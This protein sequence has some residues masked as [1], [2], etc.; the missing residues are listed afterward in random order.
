MAARRMPKPWF[1]AETERNRLLPLL[2]PSCLGVGVRPLPVPVAVG[3]AATRIEAYYCERCA[4]R[5]ERA[6]TLRAARWAA[7][8]LVGIGVAT[9]A[10]LSLGGS[11]LAL[12]I[13]LT[14]VASLLPLGI[15]WVRSVKA[16]AA[17]YRDSSAPNA[18][19]WLAREREYLRAL[20]ASAV[21]VPPPG[22]RGQLQRELVPVLVA[23]AWLA[24]LHWIGRAELRVIHAGDGDAIVLVDRRRHESFGPTR[25][26]HPHAA[27]AVSTLAGRRSLTLVSDEGETVAHVTATLMPGR[28]YLFGALPEG[29]CLF[30]ERREY[31]QRGQAHE[32]IALTR[33][34]PL[35]ELPV[36]VDVW[37]SPLREGPNLP[38]SGG[39][40]T[41]IRLRACP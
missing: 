33:S 35:W 4:D 7:S 22:Q 41:A 40:R 14:L 34:G 28:D 18:D 21:A 37:F 30:I 32:F 19:R 13:C 1:Q 15:G 2:C 26:E 8:A 39:I 24:G 9:S 5:L 25:T 20:G 27:R 10:A 38:T 12:Q 11:R 3:E 23:L 6:K 31:G 36:N 29:S 16:E 17:L